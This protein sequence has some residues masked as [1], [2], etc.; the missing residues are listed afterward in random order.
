MSFSFVYNVERLRHIETGKLI[1]E[2]QFEKMAELLNFEVV[3]ID[4]LNAQ[5]ELVDISLDV[6]GSGYYSPGR[7]H[8]DPLDCYPEE[9]EYELCSITY[10]GQDWENLVT[11]S[12]REAILEELSDKVY[13]GE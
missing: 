3:A 9:F 6:E 10:D 2:S 13:H 5:Y 4:V 1:T 7:I 11:D 8:G 12:E